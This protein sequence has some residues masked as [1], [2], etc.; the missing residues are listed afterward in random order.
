MPSSA[1][2]SKWLLEQEA[3]AL[4]T[5]LARLRPLALSEPTVPAAALPLA[6][7]STMDEFLAVERRALRGRVQQFR[8][9]LRS[10]EGLA[11][12]PA[13]AQRRFSLLRL[14]FNQVLVHLDI[15]S[16]ALEQ[17]GDPA[18]G[19]LRSGLESAA[20]DALTT[21]ERLFEPPPVICYIDRGHGAAIRRARTR[22]PGGGD[23]PVA[24]VRLPRERMVGSGIASSLIHEVGHQAAAL[25]GWL[26]EIRSV[27][28]E[29]SH[30]AAWAS[31][32]RWISEIVAD[33]W[34]VGKLGVGATLGLMGVL[35]L[36][37]AFVFRSNA[38][39]PHPTPWIRFM[40]SCAMGQSL[41]PHPQWRRLEEVWELYYPSQSELDGL[42]ATLP[43][44]VEL[45]VD[46]P[47]RCL[48]G[49]TF[50][51]AIGAGERQPATLAAEFRRWKLEPERMH[52]APP[53]LLLAALGQARSD[54]A[55]SPEQESRVLTAALRAW[56]VE[57]CKPAAC[58]CEA[59]KA[60]AS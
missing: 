3:R 23:N 35:S 50:R 41:F 56:A 20:A 6:T 48:R 60:I 15:F 19:V 27:L 46:R 24:I 5:R 33:L 36:P 42:R 43:E 28:R 26:P 1:A 49:T 37:R 34:S 21:P 58:A 25:L 12:D 38:S 53:V 54:G 10:P 16:D 11:A 9:W 13:Y 44:V 31:W 52:R 14:R 39:D 51:Q 45:L 7:L 32:D 59:K 4:L 55:I 47:L 2:V 57:R 18:Q 30:S 40:L 17:R 8:E 29:R 22:L